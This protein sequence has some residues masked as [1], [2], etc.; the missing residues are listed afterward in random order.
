[1]F[2]VRFEEIRG[3]HVEEIFPEIDFFLG[4]RLGVKKTVRSVPVIINQVPIIED[5]KTI[6]INIAF[7]DVS[8]IEGIAKELEVV[9]EL[10]T[11]L[12]GVLRSSSDGVFVSDRNGLIKYVNEKASQLFGVT[13]QS[14]T[15]QP[16]DNFLRS[17]LP[18]QVSMTGISEVDVCMINGKSCIASHIPLKEDG[19]DGKPV[20]V[21]S[22]VYFAENKVAE[23]ITRKWFSLR[24]Q[25]QYYRDELEIQGV[26]KSSFDQIV[27]RNPEL[28][29][30]KEEAQH[31]AQ[32]SST[33]L[34]TG[35]SG[36]GKDMFARAIHATSQRA[37]HPFVKVNCAAI[38]ETLL[39]SELF[40]YAPGSFT[41]ALKSGR[42]GYF[43]QADQGTI[44]L[45]EIGDMPL[46]IQV[47]ILQVI[48]EKQFMRVGGTSPQKVDVRIIAATNRDLR[49]AIAKGAFREDLFYRLD[50]IQFNLPPLR[51]RPED[52]LPLAEVFIQKYNQ[53]LG[54][55]VVGMSKAVQ[56]ALE[57]HSWPGNVRELENAIE[58]AANY[59]WEG[60]I[61]IEHLPS[62]ILQPCQEAPSQ[63]SFFRA[64]LKDVDDDAILDALRKTG[65]NKS[66]AARLLKIGR[67]AFY[68]KL[69]KYGII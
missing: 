23:E 3:R 9:K 68:R 29:K 5:K 21:V 7:L 58:R 60:E 65:G 66:A 15:G 40:G 27:S 54:T 38:P 34:L 55:S 35:E 67:S 51:R 8:D 45:D 62:H 37:N 42:T 14:L 52:I 44:F 43:G 30:K 32:S 50:V 41:G 39:E 53:I 2:G 12:S 19:Q 61:G 26:E 46:S 13:P 10:E 56:E 4:A 49:E 57:K 18:S 24:Q 69:T 48:Q 6:G 20:G 11:A 47:K 28:N 22:T 33:I 59:A 64:P 16:L 31:I 63:P 1:M 25:A 36:V 17:S